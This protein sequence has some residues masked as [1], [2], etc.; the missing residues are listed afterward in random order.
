MF[1]AGQGA[2]MKGRGFAVHAISSP[3][4]GLTEFV[5]RD[6][7]T[8][9]EVEVCRTISPVR[10]AIA[11]YRLWRLL[12][13]ISPVIVEAHTSKA[14]ILGMAAAWI[15]GVPIRIYHN[16]GMAL[17]SARGIKRKLL[18]WCEKISCQLAHKVIYVAES[19]R[20]AALREGV[21][22]L[23]KATAVTSINGLDAVNRF[24]PLKAGFNMRDGIRQRCGIPPDVLVVGFVGRLFRVKGVE[25]LMRAWREVSKRFVTAHML[26]V[27]APD[28]MVP[29]PTSVNNAMKSDPRI[30]LP[31]F[32]HDPVPYYSAMDL[33][34]LP[35]HHEGLGYV[36]LEASAMGL[37][38]IG[39]RIPGI[40]DA[41]V[42]DVTGLLV[43]PG[44][45]EGLIKA[46]CTYLSDPRLRK[47][48][49][50]A[51]RDYV[52]MKFSQEQVWE[53]L[54]QEYHEALSALDLVC[55]GQS[56]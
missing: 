33:L 51:G 12:R 2:Y 45:H 39:T 42:E 38:V 29:L 56:S 1:F 37:P 11:L 35:S 50:L 48:H 32:V 15:A 40:M 8:P 55:A 21:C 5:M 28:T 49:G 36:L 6:H 25:D 24:N 9:H 14:G 30:H 47:K 22:D 41:I 20:D 27:G 43:E 18:W 53:R 16:H 7:V 17:L 31:G 52:L 13:R 34:V 54:A 23:R 10:D 4:L 44:D 26:V 46:M 19:V 3:G